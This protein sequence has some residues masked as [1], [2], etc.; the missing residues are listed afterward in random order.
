[1]LTPVDIDDEFPMGASTVC[2]RC[3][4]ELPDVITCR[5]ANSFLQESMPLSGHSACFIPDD[6]PIPL[7][8]HLLR[9][10]S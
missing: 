3:R 6:A 5:G 4:H 7:C 1:M 10:A 9:R 2:N 8:L